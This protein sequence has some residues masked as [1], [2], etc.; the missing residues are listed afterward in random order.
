MDWI[1]RFILCH[2]N[3]HHQDMGAD[4]IQ[5]YITYLANERQVAVFTQNQY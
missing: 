3:R 2:N 4:E 5:A 1:K